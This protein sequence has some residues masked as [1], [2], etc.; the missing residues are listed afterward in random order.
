MGKNICQDEQVKIA[1]RDIRRYIDSIDVADTYMTWHMLIKGFNKTTARMADIAMQVND[2]MFCT[3][4]TDGIVKNYDIVE[5]YNNGGNSRFFD[6]NKL[7][8]VSYYSIG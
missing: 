4:G 5:D 1:I 8:D 7:G 2:A 3:Q 6:Y